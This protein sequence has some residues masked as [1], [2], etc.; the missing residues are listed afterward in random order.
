MNFSEQIPV[1]TVNAAH[2]WCTIKLLSC[3]K[4]YEENNSYEVNSFCNQEVLMEFRSCN[5]DTLNAPR[6]CLLSQ[7]KWAHS[8][9][10]PQFTQSPAALLLKCCKLSIVSKHLFYNDITNYHLSR[11]SE[12]GKSTYLWHN[13]QH[14]PST[15]SWANSYSSR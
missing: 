4:S 2:V 14:S 9:H 10:M 5:T 7:P 3:I 1:C 12:K 11:K 8:P 15:S 13:K 6:P